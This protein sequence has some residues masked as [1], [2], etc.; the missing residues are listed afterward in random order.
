MQ[1]QAERITQAQQNGEVLDLVEPP[2]VSVVAKTSRANL[3]TVTYRDD[4]DIHIVDPYRVPRDLCEPC[5]PRIRAR[6][7]SGVT[8]I[9]GVLVTRK[10]IAITRR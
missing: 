7:K 2:D 8:D 5:M 10:T 1:E 4:F 3:G 9:P 6:V